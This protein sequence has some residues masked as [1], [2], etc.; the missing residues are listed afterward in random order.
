MLNICTHYSI[1]IL[2]KNINDKNSSKLS[3]KCGSLMLLCKLTTNQRCMKKE[4][5]INQK[6]RSKVKLDDKKR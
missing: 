2:Q 4:Y 1:V 3:T 6:L 5:N